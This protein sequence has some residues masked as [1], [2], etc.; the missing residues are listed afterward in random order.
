[1]LS[2]G[3][4][5]NLRAVSRSSHVYVES[6]DGLISNYSSVYRNSPSSYVHAY[7]PT[8]LYMGDI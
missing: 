8:S 1:M 3:T 4:A 6:L 2:N 7:H 5:G